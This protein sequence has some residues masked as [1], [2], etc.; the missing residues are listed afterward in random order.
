MNAADD[1]IGRRGKLT[2][3]TPLHLAIHPIETRAQGLVAAGALDV[4]GHSDDFECAGRVVVDLSSNR[5]DGLHST[6][7]LLFRVDKVR[8]DPV[9]FKRLER[10]TNAVFRREASEFRNGLFGRALR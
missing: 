6:S 7:R 9:A 3:F 4:L 1:P 10:G 2:Q 5:K 8:G